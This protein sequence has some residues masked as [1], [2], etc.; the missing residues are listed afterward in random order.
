MRNINSIL[1]QTFGNFEH[2]IVDDNSDPETEKIV[3][4]FNDDRILLLKHD[5]CKGASAAYN[6][7]LKAS[8]GEFI[9]FLD[10]DD[11]YLPEYLEKIFKH[12]SVVSEEI[13]FIW[14]G[15][16][17]INYYEHEEKMIEVISWKTKFSIKDDAMTAAS[18]IGNGFGL[19]IRRKCIEKTGFY[20]EKLNVCCDTDF[21]I[22]LAECFNCETLPE[23]LVR[24]HSHRMQ[25]LTNATR[26]KERIATREILFER[27]RELF[28]AY[29]NM[30]F[31]HL[32]SFGE[33]CYLSG[34]QSKGRNAF[35]NLIKK[36]PMRIRV[37]IELISLEFTKKSFAD[38]IT[39][40]FIRKIWLKYK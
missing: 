39:G 29:P 7:G 8:R 6:T 17:R 12:F 37:Y 33:L 20:D 26:D 38:T 13:G 19:C 2:I 24:V 36:Y 25:C 9:T 40:N 14:T 22:R 31:T 32:K 35:F 10:D 34:Y 11:E 4:S 27:Y 15:I 3:E 28:D 18:S 1:N 30:Y 23:I 5:R 21:L 16:E